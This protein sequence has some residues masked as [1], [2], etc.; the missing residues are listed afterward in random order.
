MKRIAALLFILMHFACF[1][2]VPPYITPGTTFVDGQRLTAAELA[3][4]VSNASIN[5]TFY[6]TATGETVLGNGDQILVLTS[7]N[8]Y[9][10][11]SAANFILNNTNSR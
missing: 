2:Q 10:R 5:Y 9:R 1:G 4:L 8:Q 3:A 6:S 11:I 7:G